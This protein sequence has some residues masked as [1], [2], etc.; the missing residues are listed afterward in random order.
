M[1]SAGASAAPEDTLALPRPLA[2]RLTL[3]LARAQLGPLAGR[4][5]LASLVV[6]SFALVA[7]SAGS[8]S[9]LVSHSR[10]VFPGWETG[11]LHPLF[12]GVS[13]SAVV[14]RDGFSALV[15]VMMVVYGLVL[16]AL[17]R[18]SLRAIVVC[19]AALHVIF[20]LGPPIQSN[21]LFTY[22]GYSRLGGLHGFNPYSHVIAEET[23]DPAY[24]F[25][26]WRNLS[27]PYGPLFTALTYPLAWLPLSVAFWVLKTAMTL[28]SLALLGLIYRCARVLK[29]DPRYVLAFVALNP[30]YFVYALGGFHNDFLML[31]PAFGAILLVLSG[32]DRSA[33]AL[34][35]CAVAIKFTM[36]LLLPFL[37]V[38][39]RPAPRRWRVLTG[40]VLAVIPLIALSIGLFGFSIPNLQDQ[41]R[42]LTEFSVPNVVGDV[43]GA[44]GGA[45]W[46][47]RLADVALI[48][49]VIVL[50]RRRGDWIS[51]AG[52]ATLA[53]ILSL[54]WLQPWYGIW[55]APLAALGTSV[56]LRRAML[57]L[58]VFLIVT[59]LPWTYQFLLSHGLNP[60]AGPAGQA[61]QAQVQRLEQ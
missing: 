41:S 59:S 16:L 17:R 23:Y 28:C 35:M 55:L 20:L 18:L 25:S 26:G 47:L 6:G 54:A 61:S 39:V 48:I 12:S 4:L 49:C 40:A 43:I 33:G 46:L 19:I 22:L 52:W 31:L 36:V 14:V 58:T 7:F 13:V 57:A 50:L 11:P 15:M 8:P 34:L 30:I 21:D 38:A 37:L 32:R 53:L 10:E 44:G 56:R 51:R 27:S 24:L 60:L 45:T 3:P 9:V 5:A 29:R 42:L 2:G 1:G